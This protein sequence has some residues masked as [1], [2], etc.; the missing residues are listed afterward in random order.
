MRRRCGLRAVQAHAAGDHRRGSQSGRQPGS[1]T[2]AC[3]IT[4]TVRVLK[5]AGAAVLA[6]PHQFAVSRALGGQ[7]QRLQ[8]RHRVH[9]RVKM[10]Y[11]LRQRYPRPSRCA[12]RRHGRSRP[13]AK[14]GPATLR[15]RPLHAT[16][17]LVRHSR[18]LIL[19]KPET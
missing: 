18:R 1:R 6:A 4:L 5:S 2:A 12:G 10:A 17:H 3:R 19:P 15:Y 14:A 8:A 11:P 16:A 13:L 7:A 9:A